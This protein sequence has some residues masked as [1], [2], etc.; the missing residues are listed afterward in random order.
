MTIRIGVHHDW[1]LARQVDEGYESRIPISYYANIRRVRRGTELRVTLPRYM[2][3]TEPTC[4][5]RFI[6]AMD[7]T[8]HAR[9]TGHTLVD[10]VP[11]FDPKEMRAVVSAALGVPA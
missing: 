9:E 1:M 3:C 8:K 5:K 11:W 4:A 10:S 7:A 2:E 6:Y